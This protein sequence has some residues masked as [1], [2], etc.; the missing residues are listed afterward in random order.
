M[1]GFV[2]G[3]RPLIFLDGTHI[4]N[5]YKGSLLSAVTKDPNDDLF[6]V[7]YA[8]VDAEN[9]DNWEWFL[10][11][12]RSTLEAHRGI[13]FGSLTFFSDRHSGLIKGIPIVFPNSYH[14]YYLRHLVDNFKK[15]VRR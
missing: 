7:A 6:T 4:K 11:K 15:H 3:C 12:L 10:W 14:A 8:V 2:N 1:V 13:G 5:K 9:D